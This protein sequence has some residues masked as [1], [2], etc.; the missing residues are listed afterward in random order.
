MIS[1][2]LVR[3]DL[4][5]FR[6]GGSTGKPLE[7]CITEECS[8]LRNACAWRHDGWAGWKPGE[9]VGAVWGNPKR[10]KTMKEYLRA[11]LFGPVIFLDTMNVTE[12]AVRHFAGEWERVRPTLMFGHS[13]SI[14]LLAGYVRKMG[15]TSI[16][17]K[18]IITSSMMLMEHERGEIEAVFGKKVTNR[19]GCEEVSLIASECER[20]A[21]LHLNIEHL[22]IEFIREDGTPAK[23]GEEGK[24]VVTDLMNL[25]M[26]FIRYQV[27]DVGVPTDR[28]CP[29]GRGL[30][31]ME[32]V[33][34]RTADFL[35][36]SDGSRV[37]GVSLIE[38][39]LTVYPGIE[40]MQL[41][42]EELDHLLVRVVVNADFSADIES[43]LVGYFRKQFPGTAVQIRREATIEQEKSGKFRFAICRIENRCASG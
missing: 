14:F 8:E 9:P 1:D 26:P 39:T 41:V 33:A 29:C 7:I 24:I 35:V 15:I 5:Q 23:P 18:G 22:F 38:N 40:Q 27:E 6:T 10:P 12:D 28:R 43:S 3:S 31:L 30:P 19:Y 2:G 36:R 4:L 25:A 11:R 13:H 21:G 37:A 32:K 42:Q 16:R 20:H 17:P 34:G